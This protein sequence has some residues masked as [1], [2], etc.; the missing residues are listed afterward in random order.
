MKTGLSILEKE[1]SVL[2]SK[3][4]RATGNE[5]TKLLV[6]IMDIDEQ[7]EVSKKREKKKIG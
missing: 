2:M 5:R 7:L 4:T 1:R 3:W 6:R